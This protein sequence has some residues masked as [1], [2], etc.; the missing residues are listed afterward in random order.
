MGDSKLT[1]KREEPSSWTV[2][3]NLNT[4]LDEEV[5]EFKAKCGCDT[6]HNFAASM[7]ILSAIRYLR[8]FDPNHDDFARDE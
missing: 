2:R 3:Q 7:A 1:E 6:G 5:G 8:K 4:L